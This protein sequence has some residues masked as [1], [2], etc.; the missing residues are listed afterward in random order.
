MMPHEIIRMLAA[1]SIDIAEPRTRLRTAR[2]WHGSTVL[3]AAASLVTLGFGPRPRITARTV[4]LSL[5]FPMAYLVYTLFRGAFADWYPY[6]FIDVGER[7]VGRVLLNCALVAVLFIA[8]G[9]LAHLVDRRLP[10]A[11]TPSSEA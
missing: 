9:A 7:G 1:M 11:P 6:P 10:P 8:C 3:V 5:I 4:W 2:R